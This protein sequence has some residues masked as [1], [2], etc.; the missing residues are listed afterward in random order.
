[1]VGGFIEDNARL[2]GWIND[3]KRGMSF[4]TAARN[5][6]KFMIDYTDLSLFEKNVLKRIYPFYAWLRK[7]SVLQAEQLIKQTGKFALIPR[8]KKYIESLSE[9]VNDKYLPDYYEDLAAI[10]TPIKLGGQPLY[11]NPNFPWQDLS[12]LTRPKEL[13]SGINPMLKVPTELLLNREAY[14][15]RDIN[16]PG[17]LKPA[18]RYMQALENIIPFEKF[19]PGAER[20]KEGQLYITGRQ[21]YLSRQIPFIYNIHKILPPE[22]EAEAP[23]KTKYITDTL[24]ALAGI[25]F[26][27]YDEEK[28]KTYYYEDLISRINAELKKKRILGEEVPTLSEYKSALKEMYGITVGQKYDIEQINKLENL[29]KFTGSSAEMNLLLKLAKAQIGRAH[30]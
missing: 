7:N 25:K 23:E 8:L 29:L 28:N 2:V 5:T 20:G 21:E 10:R 11:F 19:L 3:L 14:F 9:D 26:F 22:A 4:D 27:P 24:S 12:K 6:K 16:V 1:M 30:V 15:G 18:P 13:I 17:Q